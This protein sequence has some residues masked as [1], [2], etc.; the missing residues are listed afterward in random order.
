MR[1][2]AEQP[3]PVVEG[4]DA[5]ARYGVIDIGSNSI[6]LVVF[7]GLR[8][9][10]LPLFNE[11]ILCGLGRNLHDTGRLDP[12]G[13]EHALVNL[14]RFGMLLRAMGVARF[15]AIATAAVRDA[16]DGPAFVAEV[17]RRC[18]IRVRVLS[19]AEEAEMAALGVLS[20]SPEADGVMGDLGGGSLE[21]VHLVDGELAE[22]A[23]LP[24]G[25]LNL[26]AASGGQRKRALKI[27]DEALAELPWL[28]KMRGRAFYAVG[29]NWRALAHAHMAHAGYPLNIIHH[30]RL[31][32][33]DLAKITALV[34]WQSRESL[35]G[36]RG[37][38]SRRL[39]LLPLAALVMDRLLSAAAPR[40]VVFSAHGLREG[41]AYA[42]LGERGRNEDPL[43]SAVGDISARTAR[44][45]E[46]ASELHDWTQNLF[47]EETGPQRRLRH[48]AC[49]LCDIGWRVHP[50][51]RAAQSSAEVL[52]ARALHVNH[53]ERVFLSLAVF[54]RYTSRGTHGELRTVERLLDEET[55]RRARIIGSAVRLGE[56]L[57]GGVPGVLERFSL[58]PAPRRGLLKLKCRRRDRNML[59]EVVVRRFEALAALM[60]LTPELRFLEDENTG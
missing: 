39:D 31:R 52:H 21:L 8:R 12:E 1:K 44:F 26:F 45:P 27:I 5:E 29:G 38:S 37:V 57:C 7:E 49:L 58:W 15:D 9:A 17:E 53:Q 23:T 19:G 6:R 60:E 48:A 14:E 13:I 18:G 34:A 10:P 28:T 22:Q 50:D 25:P 30:Y 16:G 43:L 36:L 20:G 47:D 3:G 41:M 11:K 35:T 4:T 56:T 42:R 33:G 2:T 51:Y 32:C 40:D 46:H 54:G 59:G 24:L 55:A